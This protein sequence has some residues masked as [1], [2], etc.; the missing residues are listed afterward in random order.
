MSFLDITAECQDVITVMRN[1]GL[2]YETIKVYERKG[3]EF[4]YSANSEAQHVSVF[5]PDRPVKKSEI[6]LVIRKFFNR[7]RNRND[8]EILS[9]TTGVIH[10]HKKCT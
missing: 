4:I 7:N 6:D 10:I 8:I 2:N 5:N 3:T 1:N 9:S